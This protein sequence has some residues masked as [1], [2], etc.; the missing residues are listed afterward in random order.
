MSA[1]LDQRQNSTLRPASRSAQL[2]RDTLSV[3]DAII[4]PD[5]IHVVS[6]DLE[7]TLIVWD[8][9]K[10]PWC[11][12]CILLAFQ[13]SRAVHPNLVLTIDVLSIRGLL[14]IRYS[15]TIQTRNLHQE[16]A[17]QTSSTASSRP[18][19]LVWSCWTRNSPEVRFDLPFACAYALSR[20]PRGPHAPFSSACQQ[21]GAEMNDEDEPDTEED[22]LL[23]MYLLLRRP[24][25]MCTVERKRARDVGLEPIS[26]LA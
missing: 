18:F 10:G 7:N 22:G 26:A 1:L 12:R 23:P 21:M 11:K 13:C 14:V 24:E 6:K 8:W 20:R 16:Y 3:W 19:C 25:V 9:Q 15:P 5:K 17:L 4:L 2:S